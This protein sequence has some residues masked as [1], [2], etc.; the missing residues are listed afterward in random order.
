MAGWLTALRGNE[1]HSGGFFEIPV[2][3]L[4]DLLVFVRKETKVA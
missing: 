1:P 2:Q 4:F 3:Q